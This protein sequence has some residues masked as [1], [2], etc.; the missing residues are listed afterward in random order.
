MSKKLSK[1]FA[2]GCGVIDDLHLEMQ[3]NLQDE[4]VEYFV[5]ELKIDEDSIT[6]KDKTTHDEDE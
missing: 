4:L 2:C 3:G 5:A 6:V 1:K